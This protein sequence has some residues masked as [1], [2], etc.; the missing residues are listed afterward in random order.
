MDCSTITFIP[1]GRWNCVHID[2][3]RSTEQQLPSLS[4]CMKQKPSD[5]IRKL[6]VEQRMGAAPSDM[7][8]D[9][10]GGGDGGP[11]TV[12]QNLRFNMAQPIDPYQVHLLGNLPAHVK[13][14]APILAVYIVGTDFNIF[15]LSMN[16]FLQMGDTTE[17][18][19]KDDAEGSV[20]SNL[21]PFLEQ[22]LPTAIS[23][24]RTDQNH[25]RVQLLK[26]LLSSNEGAFLYLYNPVLCSACVS[27]KP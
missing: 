27:D 18:T 12:V 1:G 24:I 21:R 26:Q 11:S 13:L 3:P 4:D 5:F 23:V 8:M 20:F 25:N 9:I 19:L 22:C 6:I 14:S 10:G 17:F 7:A 16:T 2:D 15:S